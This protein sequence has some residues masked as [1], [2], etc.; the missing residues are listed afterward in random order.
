MA[1]RTRPSKFLIWSASAALALF[2]AGC[3][4][5]FP[6]SSL[7]P[8]SDVGWMIQNLF[9]SIVGWAMGIFLVVETVLIVAIV[10]FR[11]RE[12]VQDR[13]PEHVHGHTG[14]EVAWTIAPALVLLFIAVPTVRTIFR[15]GG[16]PPRAALQVQ[17][18]AHQWWWE[19]RYP[20]YHI[21]TAN[22]V[23][24][25][26]GRTAY[27]TLESADVIHSFWLPAFGGKRDVVPNRTNHLWFTP[28]A[29]GTFPGQ[30]AEFC[31]ISHANMRMRAV[32][33]TEADFD[34][35]ARAQQAP[36]PPPTAALAAQ[37]AQVYSHQ[38]CIGCHTM[39]GVSAGTIGPNLTHVGSRGTIGAGL[40]PNT[41]ENMAEWIRN[42]EAIKPGTV[43]AQTMRNVKMSDSDL[44]ALVAY[45]ESRK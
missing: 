27:F 30:C 18:I 24:L 1:G 21:T 23:H 10:R 3:A 42:T 2:A 41:P 39:E 6:Q 37:G 5:H 14:L 38:V 44:R 25:P 4:G 17:V 19:F 33:Q 9:S 22:E 43:M 35:W 36:A 11:R 26:V 45:L 34:A 13:V 29:V 32:V 16:A 20:D 31:G 8:H 40:I 15:S 7:S 28:D 12:G